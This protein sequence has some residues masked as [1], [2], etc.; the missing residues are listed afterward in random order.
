M[1]VWFDSG[2]SWAGVVSATPGLRYPADLYLEGSDQH[3]GA[4]VPGWQGGCWAWLGLGW[5]GWAGAGLG[6]AA[7]GVRAAQGCAAARVAGWQ[8]G[9]W[10][11]AWLGPGWLAATST[12]VRGCKG[13]GSTGLGCLPDLAAGPGCSPGPGE[14]VGAGRGW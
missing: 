4:R 12:G 5:L 7:R 2:S 11:W 1:D 8:G 6:W 9:S 3:R 10:G 14:L 13:V